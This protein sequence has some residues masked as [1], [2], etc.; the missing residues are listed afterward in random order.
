MS[1]RASETAPRASDDR[2]RRCLDRPTPV[3]SRSGL[4]RSA[5]G[6]E[7]H[8]FIEGFCRACKPSDRRPPWQWRDEHVR[9]DPTLGT[10]R[11]RVRRHLAL[12]QWSSTSVKDHLGLFTQGVVGEWTIPRK[13]G[14]D[15]AEQMTTE[16]R[17]EREHSR[18]RVKVLWVQER[19]DNHYLDCELV[20]DTAAVISGD[21]TSSSDQNGVRGSDLEDAAT[22]RAFTKA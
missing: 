13:T 15:Y 10:R 12:F 9:V 4:E 21:L 3:G 6:V 5:S 7:R 18:G 22:R 1:R 20:V 2:P 14:R 17:E 19:R 11:A 8:P 16:V